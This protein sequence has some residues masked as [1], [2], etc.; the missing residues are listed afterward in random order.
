MSYVMP[1]YTFKKQFV[2]AVNNGV[3]HTT[4]NPSGF[5]ETPQNG[6]DVIEGP[7][8]PKP[9]RWYASVVVKDGIVIN[10]K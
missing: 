9:H 2:E 7:H 6:T 3:K 8:N 10:A 4:F 5:F 1:D